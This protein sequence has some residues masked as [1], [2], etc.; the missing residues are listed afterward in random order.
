M[1]HYFRVS[2][3]PQKRKSFLSSFF[4]DM[5]VTGWLIFVN[6]LFFVIT[7][8]ASAI[9]SSGT[10]NPVT[11]LFALQA[12]N[13]FNNY[14]FW[15]LLTS[16]FMHAGPFHLFVN[17]LS[18]F[19]VGKFL[20][21]LIGKKR[22]FWFYIFSGIFA[23]LFFA[24]FAYFFGGNEILARLFAS[25]DTFAV[26]ASGAIFAIAGALALLTPRNKV[27]LIAG[28]IVALVFQA[29]IGTFIQS[30]SILGIIDILVTV[31]ILICIFSMFS[32]NGVNKIAI[33]IKMSFWFLP[34]AAILP[35]FIIGF[36]FPL[37]IGNMAHLG[38]YIAGLAY[39]YYLRVKYK[40]KTQLISRYFQN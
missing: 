6:V 37:P 36:F 14:Y 21:M 31:Y 4:S 8:I 23:G 19:F 24:T 27:Y 3:V 15:T 18:L 32:F 38:G 11:N 34:I 20:E 2:N 29:I 28:P 17:M 22:Y 10:I 16:M 26:G 33:P 5:S 1:E 35:L 25:P 9:F 7:L 30:K 13:L 40:R 39:G 12:N